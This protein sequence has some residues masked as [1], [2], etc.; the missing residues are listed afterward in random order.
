MRAAFAWR[1]HVLAPCARGLHNTNFGPPHRSLQPGSYNTSRFKAWFAMSMPGAALL[2]L[3]Y[4][5][6]C[7][8][9]RREKRSFDNHA[10][11]VLA[12]L[13][14]HERLQ[15]KFN[16]MKRDG[17]GEQESEEDR[18]CTGYPELSVD[19]R[20]EWEDASG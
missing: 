5:A 2:S 19:D 12:L 10:A 11:K 17:S 15:K 6:H 3:A 9:D 4:F 7:H 20:E 8:F 1:V 13:A 18:G 14:L 16:D